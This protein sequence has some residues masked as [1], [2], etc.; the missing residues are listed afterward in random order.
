MHKL[1]VLATIGNGTINSGHEDRRVPRNCC[2]VDLIAFLVVEAQ[3]DKLAKVKPAVFVVARLVMNHLI[4]CS[5]EIQLMAKG[6]K[7]N[8]EVD[9]LGGQCRL[10]NMESVSALGG[11][12]TGVDNRVQIEVEQ[13][14]L[15][16][17]SVRGANR[18][19]KLAVY[20]EG[21]AIV[22]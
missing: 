2:V 4:D 16:G 17:T 22:P 19:P 1:N 11:F 8:L 10:V 13:P 5:A 7:L 3:D 9:G 20:N 6:V 18:V 14:T 21:L 12:H 15:T